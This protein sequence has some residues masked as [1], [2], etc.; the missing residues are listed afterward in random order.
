MVTVAVPWG[1]AAQPAGGVSVTAKVSSSSTRSSLS[2]SNGID[3]RLV[4]SAPIGTKPASASA[5]RP[6]KSAPFVAV[7]PVQASVARRDGLSSLLYVA[8]TTGS[9]SVSA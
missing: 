4:P 2:M 5:P 1:C 3:T 8:R 9:D 6:L 7:S